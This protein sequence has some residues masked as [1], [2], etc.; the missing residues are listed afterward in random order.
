M[1]RANAPSASALLATLAATVAGCGTREPAPA[2]G[3]GPGAPTSAAVGATASDADPG[4][5]RDPASLDAGWPGR[6]GSILT[7]VATSEGVLE[8]E[9]RADHDG[10][11]TDDGMGSGGL[12][13]GGMDSDGM[14]DDGMDDDGR[15]VGSAPDARVDAHIDSRLRFEPDAHASALLPGFRVLDRIEWSEGRAT[16]HLTVEGWR[17]G[18]EV[19]VRIPHELLA[20]E[21]RLLVHGAPFT[22]EPG[23]HTFDLPLSRDETTILEWTPRE[24]ARA[25]R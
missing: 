20:R 9:L 24:P 19:A 8:I 15:G 22:V 16:R 21:A 18:V 11:A 7:L 1:R 13:S 10:P 23:T 12:A 4:A 5:W 3:V 17:P 25:P 2:T 14:D 6:R